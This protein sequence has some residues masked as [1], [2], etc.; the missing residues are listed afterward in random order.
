MIDDQHVVADLVERILVAPRQHGRRVGDRVAVA[1]K[2]LV[3]QLLRAL[4]LL[5]RRRKPHLERADAAERAAPVRACGNR[6]LLAACHFG[7]SQ[8]AGSVIA[9][10]FNRSIKRSGGAA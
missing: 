8:A 4:D 9:N 5:A 6:M 10:G 7:F 2:H 1:I 3:A